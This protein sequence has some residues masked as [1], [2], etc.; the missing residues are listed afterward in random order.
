[1]VE[2]KIIPIF[3]E[4]KNKPR[5]KWSGGSAP[6]LLLACVCTR[7]F[8]MGPGTTHCWQNS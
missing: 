6:C 1:M 2:L 4:N 7:V 8:G 5:G 3:P